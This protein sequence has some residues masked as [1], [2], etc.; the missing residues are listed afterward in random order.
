MR[1]YIKLTIGSEVESKNGKFLILNR[2][3]I[4]NSHPKFT[5]KCCTCGKEFTIHSHWKRA[6]C[7]Q[8][9]LNET[10]DSYIG[11]QFANYKI[12]ELDHIDGHTRWYKVECLK[13]GKISIKNIKTIRSSKVGCE[14]CRYTNNGNGKIPT[15]DAVK[16]SIRSTY[17]GGA[18]SRG[19]D[20]QL[21]KEEFDNIIES[22]CYYCGEAPT[23]HKSD[24]KF[25]KTDIPYY[26]TGVDRIDPTKGYTKENCVPCCTTCN[27]MKSD[28][29][30]YS[31]LYKIKNI[32]E[33]LHLDSICST[34]IE[35][36]SEEDGTE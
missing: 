19:L 9:R 29:S 24:Q 30:N 23:I 20:W 22:N 6:K 8:C 11:K 3:E 12:L 18:R 17:I 2:E 34:T 33:K 13:C 5:L 1:N 28:L 36:T 15:L 26:R 35:K 25:N 4:P 32:Y 14:E 10:S 31:F 27:R 21:T 16:N 7:P